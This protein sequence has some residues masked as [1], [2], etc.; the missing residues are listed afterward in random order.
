MKL[1]SAILFVYLLMVT[2]QIKAQDWKPF[3]GRTPVVDSLYDQALDNEIY[4]KMLDEERRKQVEEVTMQKKSWLENLTFGVQFYTRQNNVLGENGS[5]EFVPSIG[6]NIGINLYGIVTTKNRIRKAERDL[7]K[8]TLEKA[9]WENQL[10]KDVELKYIDY[11]LALDQLKNKQ[12]ELDT[13]KQKR[14]LL[15]DRFEKGESPIEAYMMA[16]K[17]V[18]ELENELLEL[19][20]N[21]LKSEVEIYSL[22]GKLQEGYQTEE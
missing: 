16:E 17:E 10:R 6:A 21:V 19:K 22:T 9:R 8:A 18:D 5:I 2:A 4:L 15:K 20:A 1:I 7:D 11:M 3:D 13:A 12:K 14:T